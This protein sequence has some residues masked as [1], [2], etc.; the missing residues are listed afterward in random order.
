M[1][2]TSGKHI[3]YEQ[4]M[5][6]IPN[7]DRSPLRPEQEERCL[8]CACYKAHLKACRYTACTD[9]KSPVYG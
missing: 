8:L 4:L 2:F 3:F 7:F 5:K 6:E 9:K 1:L